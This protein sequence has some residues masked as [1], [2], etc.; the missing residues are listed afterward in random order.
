MPVPVG[1][2]ANA[3]EW[4]S[5]GERWE[6]LTSEMPAACGCPRFTTDGK[7]LV[8]RAQRRAGYEADKWELWKASCDAS[9]KLTSKPTSLTDKIDRS[10][11]AICTVGSDRVIATAEENGGIKPFLVNL[12][13]ANQMKPGLTNGTQ[14]LDPSADGPIGFADLSHSTDGNSFAWLQ[15]SLTSPP[16]VKSVKFSS[17]YG[18]NVQSFD[19]HNSAA[20][21]KLDLVKGESLSVPGDAGTPMQMC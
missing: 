8:F 20:L 15:S 3:G 17:T 19:E 13:E 12:T 1:G 5:A 18:A 6:T 4:K 10:F 11:D 21:A 2:L 14:S 7:T 9:G 16:V